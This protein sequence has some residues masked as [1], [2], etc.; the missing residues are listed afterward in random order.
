[1][2]D[3]FVCPVCGTDVD[4]DAIVCPECGSDDETGWSADA[5]YDGLFLLSDEPV[6]ESSLFS[7]YTQKIIGGVALA[8]VAIFLISFPGGLYAAAALYLALAAVYYFTQIRPQSHSKQ[9]KRLY[10]NLLLKA[11]GDAQLV[12]RWLDYEQARNP[13]LDR[14]ELMQTA[15]DRWERDD[16]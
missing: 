8:V 6:S 13:H 3:Y 9:E 2:S 5:D 4:I 10:Q 16:R 15:V 11:R 12:E 1:M 7:P 14:L